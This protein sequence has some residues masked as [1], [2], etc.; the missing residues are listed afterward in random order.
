MSDITEGIRTRRDNKFKHPGLPDLPVQGR[1]PRRSKAQKAEDDKILEEAH[2]AQE[3]AAVEG[4]QWLAAMQMVMEE[5]EEQGVVTKPKP[6]KPHARPVKKKVVPAKPAGTGVEDQEESS[7]DTNIEDGTKKKNQRAVK[8]SLKDA[9]N[10]ARGSLTGKVELIQGPRVGDKKGKSST[11]TTNPKF[12]L[13]KRV[14]GWIS[15]ISPDTT[16]LLKTSSASK[17]RTTA[18]ALSLAHGPPSSAL[19]SSCATSGLAI[20]T[21]S[22]KSKAPPALANASDAPKALVGR[23][24]DESDDSQECLD[25]FIQKTK[26]KQSSL[27]ITS[28]AM[29]E[30]AL[31]STED[32]QD[33]DI[34]APMDLDDALVDLED[35]LFEGKDARMSKAVDSDS[36]LSNGILFHRSKKRKLADTKSSTLVLESTPY[37]DTSDVEVIDVPSGPVAMANTTKTAVHLTSSTAIAV[38]QLATTKMQPPAKKV[39]IEEDID[40]STA[41]L[42]LTAPPGYWIEKQYKTR[43]SY[44]NYHLPPHCQD[45]RWP[46]QFLPTLYLWAGS[47]NDLWQFLDAPLVEALQSI[48]DVV[49]SEESDLD[50]KVTAQGSVFGV[51]IQRLAEWRSNFGST[52]LA[53]MMDFF[54]RN[55][56]TDPETLADALLEDFAFI[57]EDMENLDP[58][59]AFRSPFMLQLFATAHLHAILGHVEVPALKTYV[60]SVVGMTGVIGICAASLERAIKRLRVNAIDI[61]VDTLDL[62]P[63]QMKR[64]LR[65][66]KTFNKATGKDSTT[67]NAFS[68]NN[69]G[70]VTASYVVAIKAKGDDYMRTTTLTARKLLKKSGSVGLQ[71]YFRTDD[72]GS[73]AVDIRAI[74]W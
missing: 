20:T 29:P 70:S 5:A 68:I 19:S 26:G 42:T 74:L 37:E 51:A 30:D 61:D 39:K 67:E 11:A 2:Q 64:K 33:I 24:D 43:S 54:T 40:A 52:G 31:S 58:M 72:D 63:A 50:Y 16:E 34:D 60:L 25:A 62:G 22:S 53:S 13:I 45:Q 38:S 23:F 66:P 35:N 10:N 8:T 57:Y 12:S 73:E 21:K 1:V 18:S 28:D 48:Y 4:L 7:Q 6:V 36:S 41:Q 55:A 46:K 71:K 3:R 27:R 56:D 9:I 44:R 15:D 69:W 14:D 59:Q 47:Q 49:Y 17:T 32:L 65:T